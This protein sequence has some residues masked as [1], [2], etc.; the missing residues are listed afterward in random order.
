MEA[1]SQLMKECYCKVLVNCQ[2]LGE[3]VDTGIMVSGYG[4]A[5]IEFLFG[6]GL[7][8]YC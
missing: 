4:I 3:L 7:R 6:G 1:G 5:V 2:V 8:H